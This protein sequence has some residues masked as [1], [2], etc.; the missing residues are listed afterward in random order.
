MDISY[1]LTRAASLWPQ[2][3]AVV[4]GCKRFTYLETW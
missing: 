1:F 4:D 2:K 3:E